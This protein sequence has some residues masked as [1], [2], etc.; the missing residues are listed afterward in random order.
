M[1]DEHVADD[2]RQ[3]DATELR[4]AM[5]E[6]IATAMRANAEEF[7]RRSRLLTEQM[8]LEFRTR[9]ES[10]EEASTEP[11]ARD[12]VMSAREQHVSRR[13][14]TADAEQRLRCLEQ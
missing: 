11:G 4:A 13:R 14:A 8:Q 3:Q 6:A 12:E 9:R 10:M 1:Q 2:A 7:D 5:E